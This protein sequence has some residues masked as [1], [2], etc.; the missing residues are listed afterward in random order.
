MN[1]D[2]A[3]VA[4]LEKEID[5]LIAKYDALY[6]STRT[7]QTS[8]QQFVAADP[9]DIQEILI[10]GTIPAGSCY[11]FHN[12]RYSCQIKPTDTIATY[13]SLSVT[14]KMWA[15]TTSQC[16]DVTVTPAPTSVTIS[17]LTVPFGMDWGRSPD[18]GL[19][20]P[21]V[22]HG[23]RQ[24]QRHYY[25]YSNNTWVAAEIEPTYT[26]TGNQILLTPSSYGFAMV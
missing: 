8:V 19:W 6:E 23:Q 4:Q 21:I 12:G 9:S 10:G 7:I 25:D 15:I 11:I 2:A 17:P 13:R 16:G 14:F 24:Y 20:I 1:T 3:L 26:L 22:Y 5:A 18:D